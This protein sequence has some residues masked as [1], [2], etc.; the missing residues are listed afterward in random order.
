MNSIKQ[1]Q[2]VQK[3]GGVGKDDGGLFQITRAGWKLISSFS[4]LY[5]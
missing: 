4:N 1:T 3:E 5:L 2:H